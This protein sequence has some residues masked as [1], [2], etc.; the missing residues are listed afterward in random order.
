MTTT[1]YFDGF[2]NQTNFCFGWIV[3]DFIN[4]TKDGINGIGGGIIRDVYITYHV[5]NI[6][7]WVKEP[8]VYQLFRYS[9]KLTTG[10]KLSGMHSYRVLD[11][12][13]L[14]LVA[15]MNRRYQW[16]SPNDDGDEK[17][18]QSVN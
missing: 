4:R 15:G 14:K 12:G 5:E 13:K 18:P 6:P 7:D 16:A 3:V 1:Q 8:A 11:K 10:K 2:R 17:A 9:K